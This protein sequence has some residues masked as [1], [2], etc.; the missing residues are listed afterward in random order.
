[1]DVSRIVK[2]YIGDKSVSDRYVVWETTVRVLSVEDPVEPSEFLPVILN[3]SHSPLLLMD[4]VMELLVMLY[5]FRCLCCKWKLNFSVFVWR[6]QH[7]V[8]DLFLIELL[9]KDG[10]INRF[11]SFLL[12]QL[13]PHQIFQ[14]LDCCAQ[15][16]VYKSL[17]NYSRLTPYIVFF[18]QPILVFFS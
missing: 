10:F 15:V 13:S 4:M 11:I 3:N 14:S 6:T 8:T 12:R 5:V 1:M 18:C 9:Y 16:F 7:I 17:L 2:P